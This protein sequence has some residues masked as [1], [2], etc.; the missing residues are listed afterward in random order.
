MEEL[1]REVLMSGARAEYAGNS[2]KVAM[3]AATISAIF[4]VINFA[5]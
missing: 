3:I 4:S 5:L 2:S 1:S